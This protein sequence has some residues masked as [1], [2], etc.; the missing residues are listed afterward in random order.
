MA[1][2]AKLIRLPVV[3]MFARPDAASE[4]V[5]QALMGMQVEPLEAHPDWERVRT[6]DGYSGWIRSDAASEP[7]EAWSGGWCEVKDLWANLRGAPDSKAAAAIHAFVGTRLPLI[8]ARISDGGTRWVEVRVPDGRALWTEDQRVIVLRDS[9]PRQQ[10][11]LAMCRS[12]RRFLG[13]PYL[14]GG[15]SPLGLDCSGFVQLV[16]RMHG[17]QLRRDA[18]MQAEQGAAADDLRAADLVFFGPDDNSAR[19]T[20]VGMMLD[21]R[22]FI[23]AL[24]GEC[25]R[26]DPLDSRRFATRFR[27]ARRYL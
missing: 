6:P 1:S 23:H 19:I 15:C 12:A 21:A 26:I 25:V 20:H 9:P 3:P 8:G 27:F 7:S 14:W 22:R 16:Y 17:I 18:D 10:T 13:V 4:Q 24:G 2:Q 11:A 5:S